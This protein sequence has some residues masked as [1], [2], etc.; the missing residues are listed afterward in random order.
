MLKHRILY[1]LPCLGGIAV[2]L[3]RISLH[4]MNAGCAVCSY[5]NMVIVLATSALCG[6]LQTE[7]FGHLW[8][9]FSNRRRLF[10][11]QRTQTHWGTRPE[12]KP[13]IKRFSECGVVG[14]QVDQWVRGDFVEGQSASRTVHIH[15]YSVRDRGGGGGGGGGGDG[16]HHLIVTGIVTNIRAVQTP[17]LI[18]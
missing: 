14:V 10:L 6:H 3:K 2:H 5:E 4:C 16:C 15:C 1:S 17:G 12:P 7:L 8:E 9:S 18:I 13:R 11:L